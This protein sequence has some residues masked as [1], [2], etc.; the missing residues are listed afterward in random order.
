[1]GLGGAGGGAGVARGAGRAGG[2]GRSVDP[3][4]PRHAFTG[5]TQADDEEERLA[6]LRRELERQLD[7]ADPLDPGVPVPAEARELVPLLGLELRG[8]KLYPPGVQATLG[9]REGEAADLEAPL[10]AQPGEG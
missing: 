3:A 4:P 7:A 8:A 2:G 5:E 6:A 10:G 9:A 1:A